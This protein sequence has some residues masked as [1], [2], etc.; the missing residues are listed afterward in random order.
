L[1]R[2]QWAKVRFDGMQLLYG[3]D[4]Y[5][6]N[7]WSRK[8]WDDYL[9]ARKEIREIRQPEIAALVRQAHQGLK[10]VED[11]CTADDEVRQELQRR[12]DLEQQAEH[13]LLEVSYRFGDHFP[14]LSRLIN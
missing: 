9:A 14:R 13:A 7:D 10:G 4:Q 5:G 1:L 11:G 12:F 3:D 6:D 2:F 8:V